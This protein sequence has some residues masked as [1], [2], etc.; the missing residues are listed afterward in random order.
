MV[1][2]SPVQWGKADNLAHRGNRSA[3]TTVTLTGDT[4]KRMLVRVQFGSP[5]LLRPLLLAESRRL[6]DK[7]LDGMAPRNNQQ[8]PD[9]NGKSIETAPFKP[10]IRRCRRQPLVTPARGL[11]VFPRQN[12]ETC[13][14]LG[15]QIGHDLPGISPG[16]QACQA[17]IYNRALQSMGRNSL[18]G[19][20]Q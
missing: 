20:Q 14:D 19:R 16:S 7:R 1:I 12:R 10:A 17:G 9:L 13:S 18:G 6:T 5:C 15:Q 4:I 11:F 3:H 2:W 8:Q